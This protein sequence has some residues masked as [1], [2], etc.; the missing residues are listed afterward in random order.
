MRIQDEGSVMAGLAR[1]R[2]VLGWCEI[3]RSLGAQDSAEACIALVE[4]L[5]SRDQSLV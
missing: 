3:L 1:A 5:K 4:D 2:S